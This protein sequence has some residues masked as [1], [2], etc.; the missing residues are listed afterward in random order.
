MEE[1]KFKFIDQT[2][3]RLTWAVSL[4][5]ERKEWKESQASGK[6]DLDLFNDFSLLSVVVDDDKLSSR[7]GL[8]WHIFKKLGPHIAWG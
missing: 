6:Y 8:C 5:E 3:Q 2:V 4:K 1:N 7:L